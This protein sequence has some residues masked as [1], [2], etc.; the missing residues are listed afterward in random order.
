MVSVKSPCYKVCPASATDVLYKGKIY[1][2]TPLSDVRF[3]EPNTLPCTLVGENLFG[4]IE[5]SCV[6][7]ILSGSAAK[8]MRPCT[9][10]MAGQVVFSNLHR[11]VELQSL[12]M[13]GDNTSFMC[14]DIETGF[15]G[16]IVMGCTDGKVSTL[17]HSCIEK[18]CAYQQVD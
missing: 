5:F 11:N 7:G 10:G 2:L 3:E 12:L 13:H 6:N 15:N 14:N 9:A 16:E 1:S 4:N 8:C 18:N 17:E